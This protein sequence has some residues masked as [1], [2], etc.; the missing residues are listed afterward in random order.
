MVRLAWKGLVGGTVAAWPT[1]RCGGVT[2]LQEQISNRKQAAVR[3]SERPLA[4]VYLLLKSAAGSTGGCLHDTTVRPGVSPT[5]GF[6]LD[7]PV[8]VWM[9]FTSKGRE[10]VSALGLLLQERVDP[11]A[12][13]IT[14]GAVRGTALCV[15]VRVT[16]Q[17]LVRPGRTPWGLYSGWAGVAHQAGWMSQCWLPGCVIPLGGPVELGWGGRSHLQL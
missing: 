5:P 12:L 14:E 15:A 3:G 10:G 9:W 6:L 17:G 2:T 11:R 1:L 7:S 16:R 8:S 4:H 13:P